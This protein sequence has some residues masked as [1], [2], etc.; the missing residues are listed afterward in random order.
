M[1]QNSGKKHRKSGRARSQMGRRRE[2]KEGRRQRLATG[3][4]VLLGAIGCMGI[5]IKIGSEDAFDGEAIGSEDDATWNGGAGGGNK[6]R[7]L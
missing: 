5:G 2:R 6:G 1:S 7:R 3:C 4:S